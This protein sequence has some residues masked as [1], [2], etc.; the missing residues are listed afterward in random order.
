M[1]GSQDGA[2]HAAL[3]ASSRRRLLDVL[4]TDGP[5]D[6]TALAAAVGLHVTTARFHLDVLQ[7]AGLIR[8]TAGRAGKPGRPRQLYTVTASAEPREAYR[9]L[10]VALTEVLATDPGAGP[11]LAERAGRH[12]AQMEIPVED[13]LSWEEGTRRISD[14]FERIGFAP[15]VVDDTAERHLELD[16]C[17]FRDLARAYPQ[18][19]CRAHLGLLRG[20]L[21]RLGV[22]GAEHAGLR[23]FVEPELCV[24]DVPTP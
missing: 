24:A 21:D 15:R 12:W 14:L 16:A 2:R 7:Q 5:M 10:A 13:A 8:R 23:P 20:S 17:P 18:I 22:P 4:T 19:V 11:Q 1:T 3:S 6:V 9:Q